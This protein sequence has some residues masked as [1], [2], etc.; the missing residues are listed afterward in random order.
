MPRLESDDPR[1]EAILDRRQPVPASQRCEHEKHLDT[2][3]DADLAEWFCRCG[4]RAGEHEG[5]EEACSHCD[6]CQEF[7]EGDLRAVDPTGNLATTLCFTEVD[8]DHVCF[9][10]ICDGCLEAWTE[11]TW[12][13]AEAGWPVGTDGEPVEPTHCGS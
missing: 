11:P 2:L 6:G 8:D 9:I 5:M 10:Y 3:Y 12:I 13:D 1:V 7:E 4:G